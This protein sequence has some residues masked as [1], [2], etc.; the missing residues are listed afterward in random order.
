[1]DGMNND[2]SFS[3]H[4]EH[5]D[6]DPCVKSLIHFS[7]TSTYHL[8][9]WSLLS[10][11]SDVEWPTSQFLMEISHDHDQQFLGGIRLSTTSN[12]TKSTS[13]IDEIHEHIGMKNSV[14][15]RVFE[16][17][18]SSNNDPNR[19]TYRRSFLGCYPG[20]HSKQTPTSVSKWASVWF[21]EEHKL[22][23]NFQDQ[24]KETRAIRIKKN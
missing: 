9:S 19:E 4:L 5:R 21:F 24:T 11:R 7:S 23:Q 3:V 17:L 18:S 22:T 13:A 8:S 14:A 12:K 10:M 16:R 1:M 6:R 20:G 15:S 2:P